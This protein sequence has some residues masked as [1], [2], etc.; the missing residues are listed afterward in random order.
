MYGA[1]TV[2]AEDCKILFGVELYGLTFGNFRERY[3]M[4][5]FDVPLRRLAVYSAKIKTTRLADTTVYSLSGFRGFWI[6]LKFSMRHVKAFFC[7]AS[8]FE[9]GIGRIFLR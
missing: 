9:T 6:A 1:V 3:E 7:Y 5:R 4:V 8:I 2:S